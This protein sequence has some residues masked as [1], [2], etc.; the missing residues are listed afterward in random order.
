M[1]CGQCKEILAAYIEGLLN[2]SEKRAIQEHLKDCS[3]C[4]AE[5]QQ[6]RSLCDRLAAN[7]KA[8]SGSDLENVVMNQIIREQNFRLKTPGRVVF[9]PDIWRKIMKT[10]ITKFAAAAAIIVAALLGIH[11]IGNP[12]GSNVTFARVIEPILNARIVV[13]DFIVGSEGTGPVIHDIVAG[14]RIRRT[15]SNMDTIMI[16]DLD[17]AKMLT[18][19]PKTKGAAY[20]DIQGPLQE[21]TKNFIEFVRKVITNLKDL[22]VQELGQQ[23]IDGLKAIGFHASGPNEEITIWADLQTAKPIRIELL[24]AQK[25]LYILK[26]IEFDVPV[27]E[28]LVS[29][30]VPAGYTSSAKEFDM[31]QFTEQDFITVLRLWAEH[32]LGGSFPQ[33]LT[34]GDL[35][36]L[37]PQM[38]EKIGQLNIPDEEKTQL[39]M[40]MGRGF[41]FFQQLDPYGID[42]HY[43]GSGVKLG[44]ADKAIFWYQPKG[45]ATYRVI[46][47]D[48]SAKDV[49][50]E[51]LPK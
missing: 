4:R 7:G 6:L 18:L 51:N 36:S 49:A 26:N 23:N 16:I 38:G 14:N 21:G 11:F 41:V 44:E 43:A 29:M 33:S 20:I 47:G 30:D 5:F 22:P 32:L 50:P 13:F 40:T 34:V 46:Y 9:L 3:L 42:W 48:L 28:S 27:D 1:N 25:S 17:N 10:K 24:L 35:M 12:L 31:R 45:S 15:F 2:E 19:D 8:L 39:G 37:T